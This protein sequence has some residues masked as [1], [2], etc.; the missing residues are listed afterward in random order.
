M[1]F[2][3]TAP[4][5]AGDASHFDDELIAAAAERLGQ[6]GGP[7]SPQRLYQFS[8]DPL[9]KVVVELAE[10]TAIGL[11]GN[12]LANYLYDSLRFFISRGRPTIFNVT[13][14]TTKRRRRVRVHL[15][16]ADDAALEGALTALPEVL[17]SAAGTVAYDAAAGGYVPVAIEDAPV[18]DEEKDLDESEERDGR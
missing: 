13:V 10:A 4:V 7:V 17:R 2:S 1:S 18:P 8:F 12:L 14:R 15:A 5:I 16:A 3:F 6:V 11:P 9:V